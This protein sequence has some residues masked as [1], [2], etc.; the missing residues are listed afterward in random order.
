MNHNLYKRYVSQIFSS[1]RYIPKWS[2]DSTFIFHLKY[3]KNCADPSFSYIFLSKWRFFAKAIFYHPI[4]SFWKMSANYENWFKNYFSAESLS[5]C[6][7]VFHSLT[8]ALPECKRNSFWQRT[9]HLCLGRVHV[10]LARHKDQL[11]SK[12]CR[13]LMRLTNQSPIFWYS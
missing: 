12:Y 13:N 6:M 5:K 11:T 7:L 2:N 3:V 8:K 9:K 10:L 4:C 1:W